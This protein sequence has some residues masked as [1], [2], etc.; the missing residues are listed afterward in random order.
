MQSQPKA[1]S[2]LLANARQGDTP[3]ICPGVFDSLSATVAVEA[4]AK[5]LY[6][7]G[8]GI[9]ASS[10]GMPDLGLASLSELSHVVRNIAAVHPSV[11]LIVDADTG[12]GGTLMCARTLNVYARLGVAAIHVEDQVLAKRCGH[13]TG[14]EVVSRQEFA[15][16]IKAMANERKEIGSD[17]LIIARTD[18]VQNFNLQEAI[19]RTHLALEKGADVAF[20]EGIRN[21]EEAR[22]ITQQLKDVPCLINLVANGDTPNWNA[23]QVREFGFQVA[24]YPC[25][26]IVPAV[27]AMRQSVKSLL[28]SGTDVEACR[29]YTPKDF[30]L[31]LG[32]NK[33]IM[34]DLAAGG[35]T[36][37][38][39]QNQQ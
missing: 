34:K 18:A 35:N 9:V 3:L 7:S 1:L 26:S 14:K 29:G 22:Q 30:F 12:Y 36:L 28:E 31:S 33:L 11:P 23:S 4:G 15:S 38:G 32:M 27:L 17:I 2:S 19:E 5:A 25:A 16:R 8:A 37:A 20:V 10:L 39:L 24:I 21:E 6:V 13:L